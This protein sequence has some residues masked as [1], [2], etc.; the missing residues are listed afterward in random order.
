LPAYLS[1]LPR[2]PVSSAY[3]LGLCLSMPLPTSVSQGL[4]H[5][6]I[7]RCVF[8]RP[9]PLHLPHPPPVLLGEP[10]R[11]YAVSPRP[12]PPRVSICHLCL[13]LSLVLVLSLFFSSWRYLRLAVYLPGPLSVWSSLSLALYPSAWFPPSLAPLCLAL[14][15]C[16]PHDLFLSLALSLSA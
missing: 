6:D 9:A 2:M 10:S 14:S 1:P 12:L 15:L 5:R 7:H 11:T 3:L 13:A 8:Y 4:Q 16:L